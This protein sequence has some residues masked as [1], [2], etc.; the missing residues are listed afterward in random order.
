MGRVVNI[1]QT[2]PQP[3]ITTVGDVMRRCNEAAE[4][5]GGGNPHRQVM[6][7][8]AFCI[9]Q[10]LN[11]LEEFDKDRERIDLTPGAPGAEAASAE[12]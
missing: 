5:M 10:L 2:I 9:S 3:K 12:R 6:L 1:N 7:D 8:A 4:K 11:R